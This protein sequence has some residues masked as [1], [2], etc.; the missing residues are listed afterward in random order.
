[1]WICNK[2]GS[3]GLQYDTVCM[4]FRVSGKAEIIQMV[5]CPQWNRHYNVTNKEKEKKCLEGF[6]RTW[7]FQKKIFEKGPFNMFREIILRQLVKLYQIGHYVIIPVF[8]AWTIKQSFLNP[9]NKM[10]SFFRFLKKESCQLVCLN[11]SWNNN[12][13]NQQMLADLR[14][15]FK[16]FF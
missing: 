11:K 15:I 4:E 2:Q 16:V 13:N 9:G 12:F 10:I 6:Q 14:H 8:W 5:K 7:Y 3:N 1:M